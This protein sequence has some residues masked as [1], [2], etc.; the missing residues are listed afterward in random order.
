[1][2]NRRSSFRFNYS[3]Q[4]R[5]EAR[6]LFKMYT[7]TKKQKFL[8]QPVSIKPL[9]KSI[10]FA[11]RYI[12]QLIFEMYLLRYIYLHE[13]RNTELN[14]TF[15]ILCNI[16]N[17]GKSQ[18]VAENRKMEFPSIFPTYCSNNLARV[19]NEQFAIKKFSKNYS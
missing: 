10:W 16:W 19:Y 13:Q 1:M 3:Y 9:S 6:K 12:S 8:W 7:L 11:F 2:K 18:K 15:I 4:V 14:S 5:N 17:L